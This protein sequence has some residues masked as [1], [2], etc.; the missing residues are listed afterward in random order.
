M[1]LR[2]WDDLKRHWKWLVGA[3]WLLSG[4]LYL[5]LPPSPDQFECSYMGWRVLEGDVPYRDFVDMNWPGLI[6]IHALATALFGN[7][8]W[9]WHL[10]DF[11]LLAM[12]G[13]FLADLVRRAAG[14]TAAFFALLLYPV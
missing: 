11:A 4:A 6:W 2:N 8:I 13:G 10:L 3:T 5:T 14:R 12:S 9:S 7:R 1:H